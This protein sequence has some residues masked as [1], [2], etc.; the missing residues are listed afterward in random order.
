[1]KTCHLIVCVA[2]AVLF[3][4]LGQE[5]GA[6]FSMRWPQTSRVALYEFALEAL[7]GCARGAGS[8]GMG[9]AE[10]DSAILGSVGA[11]S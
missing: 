1:M 5:P 10:P 4:N 3:K 9:W 7:G 8:G 6:I 11:S 2:E